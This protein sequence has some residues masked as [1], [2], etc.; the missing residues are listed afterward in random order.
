MVI[1]YNLI[2]LNAAAKLARISELMNQLAG[3]WNNKPS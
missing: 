1:S 3:N 2:N